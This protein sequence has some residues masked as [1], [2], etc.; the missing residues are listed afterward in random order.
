MPDNTMGEDKSTISKTQSI[1]ARWIMNHKLSNSKYLEVGPDIG[2]VSKEIIQIQLPKHVTLLEPN[3]SVREELMQNVKSVPSIEIVSSL[4]EMTNSNFDLAVG[5][6]V[7][8]HLLD[9][10]GDLR[11][12][13]KNVLDRGHLAIVVHNEKSLLR[14]F[15][16]RKW[17]PFCLQH[18]QLYNPKTLSTLLQLSGWKSVAMA[19]TT[20]WYHLQHFVGLGAGVL[21]IPVG[22]S[23]FTPNFEVP[24][25]LGNFSSL[26]EAC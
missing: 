4:E 13:R 15:L 10:L 17:P 1:Y 5:I 3:L 18:P 25:K 12:L 2:L 8:D 26:S 16:R 22:I 24:I 14:Y 23:R 9:P 6:H 20:N 11:K 19:K 7:Y 21:G